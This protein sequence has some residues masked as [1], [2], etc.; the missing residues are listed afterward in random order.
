MAKGARV[1]NPQHKPTRAATRR[2]RV[3]NT[4]QHDWIAAQL[5]EAPPMTERQID[6]TATILANAQRTEAGAS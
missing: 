4:S 1:G 5:A 2:L 6:A 3:V